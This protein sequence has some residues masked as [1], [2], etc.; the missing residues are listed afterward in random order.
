MSRRAAAS[1]I[2]HWQ[3]AR[4]K[5]ASAMRWLRYLGVGRVGAD[6]AVARGGGRL[7]ARSWPGPGRGA[8]WRLAAWAPR[9]MV[10]YTSGR[11]I[12]MIRPQARPTAAAAA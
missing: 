4:E 8:A 5:N 11:R 7:A 3:G 2:S 6:D 1:G 9:P 12:L 10:A